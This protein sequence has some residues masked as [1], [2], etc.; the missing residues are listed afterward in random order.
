MVKVVLN[1]VPMYQ[2]STFKMPKKLLRQLDSLQRKLW[3]G[4]KSNKGLNLIAWS[5]MCI[6]KD[7][8]G[9]AFRDLEKLNHAL[10]AK[11]AWRICQQSDHLLTRILKAKYFKKEDFLHL[12]EERK[13]SSW[14]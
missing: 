2:M 4:F 11:L 12:I 5:N 8:G 3:W 14:T 10:L 7:L 13:N 1:A 6:S 9:L